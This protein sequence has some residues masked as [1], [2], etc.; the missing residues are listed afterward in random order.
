MQLCPSGRVLTILIAN[1]YR[2]E[3]VRLS[4]RKLPMDQSDN[5]A[6]FYPNCAN[7]ESQRPVIQPVQCQE[8]PQPTDIF[9]GAK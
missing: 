6:P 5:L 3:W 8:G 4:C 7:H 1:K 2:S 9:G